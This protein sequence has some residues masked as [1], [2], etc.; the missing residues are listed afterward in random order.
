[1]IHISQHRNIKKDKYFQLQSHVQTFQNRNV[2]QQLTVQL[3]NNDGVIAH[4]T[5]FLHVILERTGS[6]PHAQ[7]AVLDLVTLSRTSL[8]QQR[9]IRS[10]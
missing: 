1:M 2:Q 6:E 4:A 10:P 9:T 8:Q 3:I 7:C 5:A